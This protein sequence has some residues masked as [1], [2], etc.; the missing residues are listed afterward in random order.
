ML[1]LLTGVAPA[2]V[3]FALWILK[4]TISNQTQREAAQKQFLEAIKNNADCVTRAME[5]KNSADEQINDLNGK[6]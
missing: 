2:L 1:A 5:L 4:I 6:P 3:S